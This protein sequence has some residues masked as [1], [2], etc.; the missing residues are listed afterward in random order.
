MGLILPF[1]SYKIKF[2]KYISN[3]SLLYSYC[4]PENP[5]FLASSAIIESFNAFFTTALKI[6]L[7]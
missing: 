4:Y 6:F 7:A 3:F 5:L 1:L 2:L